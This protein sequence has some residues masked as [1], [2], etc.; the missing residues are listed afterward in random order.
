MWTFHHH[1]PRKNLKKDKSWQYCQSL[2]SISWKNM[3]SLKQ[4]VMSNFTSKLREERMSGQR[5]SWWSSSRSSPTTRAAASTCRVEDRIEMARKQLFMAFVSALWMWDMITTE[6]S[7]E[8]VFKEPAPQKLAF[9]WKKHPKNLL[10]IDLV[11]GLKRSLSEISL[12]T[13]PSTLSI[14][15]SWSGTSTADLEMYPRTHSAGLHNSTKTRNL[16]SVDK[17]CLVWWYL[18]FFK[19]FSSDFNSSFQ[20]QLI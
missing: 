2:T 1:Q 6:S 16:F 15:T 19:L 7:W 20:F 10:R 11:W 17:H 12:F 3:R 13:S 9:A 18:L 14:I 5:R 8:A 4:P